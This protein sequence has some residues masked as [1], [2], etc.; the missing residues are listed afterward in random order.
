MQVLYNK[1]A[2]LNK[3]KIEKVGNK[4]VPVKKIS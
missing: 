1:G 4:E 2:K 3:A